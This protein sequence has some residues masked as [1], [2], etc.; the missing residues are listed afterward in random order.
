MFIL[1]TE[2]CMDCVLVLQWC[3]FSLNTFSRKKLLRCSHKYS[4][5]GWKYSTDSINLSKIYSYNYEMLELEGKNSKFLTFYK[6]KMC[7]GAVIFSNLFQYIKDFH[8]LQYYSN[9]IIDF[10]E[11]KYEYFNLIYFS[12]IIRIISMNSILRL[13]KLGTHS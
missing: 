8:E 13:F 7:L 9:I 5:F 6:Y 12:N 11:L 3:F 2:L 10:I 4:F 1:D